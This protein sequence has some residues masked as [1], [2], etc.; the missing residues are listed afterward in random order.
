MNSHPLVR[1]LAR[2]L[3]VLVVGVLGTTL[4]TAVV[5]QQVGRIPKV[6]V[7][8]KL[9]D[10]KL[11]PLD[12][13]TVVFDKDNRA[14][15]F[16]S[17]QEDRQVVPLSRIPKALQD[18]VIGIEDRYFWEHKGVNVRATL[19]A[20]VAN[21]ASG[22]IEQGGS[23]IT[24][25]L[26]KNA[27]LGPKQTIERKVK[28][29]AF[30]LRLEKQMTKNQI[31]ERYLNA[32][33]L[34]HGAYGVQSAAN[35]YFDRN[36][37]D[38]DPAQM[39]LLVALIRNPNGYDPIDN[40]ELAGERRAV[41]AN[42]LAELKV[43]TNEVRDQIKAAPLP[44]T[45]FPRNK[46]FQANLT[47][48][49]NF[50]VEEVR[51]LM[52]SLPGGADNLYTAGWRIFTTLDVHAQEQAEAAV[53]DALPDSNGKFK[54]A[55]AAVEPVTGAVRALVGND[56]LD[57]QGSNWATQ[58]MRQ[59]G[60]SFK[61]FVLAAAFEAG[62]D[63]GDTI[64]GW[65]PCA[66]PLPPGSEEPVWTPQNY[67]KA[68]GSIATLEQ[69]TLKSNNC[70]YARLSQAVGMPKVT[71]L[72]KKLGLGDKNPNIY[73]IALGATEQTPL[74]MA[75][76]YA[77]FAGGGLYSEPRLI[78]HIT[79]SDGKVLLQS[80]LP[81]VP[82][83]SGTTAADV[84]CVLKANVESGTGTKAQIG[85]Q[86]V[87]GKTGTTDD[88]RNAWFVGYSPHLSTAVWMGDPFESEKMENVGG[89][90][91]T[92]G[93]YPAE[94]WASFMAR[95]EGDRDN[96][97]FPGCPLTNGSEFIEYSNDLDNG[98]G[99]SIP[100]EGSTDTE[101]RRY[102]CN[103]DGDRR[104][105][106][107]S[108]SSG[109]STRRRRSSSSSSSSSSSNSST[110]TTAPASA[111]ETPTTSAASGGG[112]E[113]PTTA[114]GGSGGGTDSGGGDSGGGTPTTSGGGS[115]GGGSGGA[116]ATTAAPG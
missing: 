88:Y 43:I 33:Y 58:G 59:V 44:T 34:G 39:A 116:T 54:A 90:P 107:S 98:C 36:V 76:A 21:T 7:V 115:S 3:T 37:E 28:E 66:F 82:V 56:S 105:G 67:E 97:D 62:Y 48:G 74:Q 20:L 65:G 10:L 60:S 111:G 71:E 112:G 81:Q 73:S 25:Q 103:S 8:P 57:A 51:R 75:G 113:T 91:V 16:F 92:G 109:S 100:A 69:H 14:I 40:P 77:A 84:T 96:V 13:R 95:Y 104:G 41:V 12:D 106:T 89:I 52:L 78:D 32:I 79:T 83:L 11:D 19:R 6:A 101:I 42:R 72:G 26:V 29:A 50:F 1:P 46:V 114:S 24:Q 45:L 4:L 87:A 110:A 86:D 2:F 49:S 63:R 38:L 93:S 27:L 23:T 35:I 85:S 68:S 70:A 5:A 30:A 61:P 102:A 9:P 108:T 15:A 64:S 22:D 55:I 18:A 31:L 94:I 47:I 53:R 99:V 17:R 80:E